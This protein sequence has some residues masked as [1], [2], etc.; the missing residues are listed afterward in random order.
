MNRFAYK[1]VL[2]DVQMRRTHS[3]AYQLAVQE[4]KVQVVEQNTIESQENVEEGVQ[5]ILKV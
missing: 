4:E 3:C 1:E 5:H 2:S